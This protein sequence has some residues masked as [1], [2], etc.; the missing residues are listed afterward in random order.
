MSV[1]ELCRGLARLGLDV[2]VWTTTRGYHP[3]TDAILD[4]RLKAHGV[5][6]R[7]FPVHPWGWLGQRYAYSPALRDALKE[8]MSGFDL[9]HL[10][11]LWQYP[12]RIAAWGCRQS[13][14]P[15]LLSPCGALDPYSLRIHPVFKRLYGFFVERQIIRHSSVIH[16]TSPLEQKG[17]YLFGI[18]RPC[19]IIPRSVPLEEVPEIPAGLF[20]SRYPELANRRLLLFLGR[21]HPKKRLDIVANAFVSLA[22]RRDDLH[23]VIAGPDQGAGAVVREILKRSALLN[24]VTFTGLLTGQEKWMALRDSTFFL[25]PSE[26]ENFGV[27]ALEAMAVGLPVLLSNQV[28]LADWVERS[29]AGMVL[30]L[31][32][33]AWV[34][35]IEQLLSNPAFAQEMGEAAKQLAKREFSS[36]RVANAMHRV[37]LKIWKN[38]LP[39][40]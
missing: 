4:E 6:I 10:H 13:Q 30:P 21:M 27:A 5:K 11:A 36:E 31:K 23:L 15:Y 14:T 18:R 3:T 35:A 29:R 20:R 37:Y 2:A 12:A 17:A 32:T 8:E 33:E 7:Y 34:E 22:R 24:R 39:S 9:I 1:R 40:R 19:V 25:L 28:G 26:E 38:S 16:F